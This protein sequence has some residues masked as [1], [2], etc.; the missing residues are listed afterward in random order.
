MGSFAGQVPTPLLATYSGTKS[1]LISFSQTLG[2]ELRRSKIDVQ[3]LNTYFVVSNMSKIRRSSSMI[4][5]PRQYVQQ[6]LSKI[7]RNG[8]AIGRA[9]TMTIWP[10]HALVDWAIQTF[11]FNQALF[12]RYNYSECADLY[13]I[14]RIFSFEYYSSRSNNGYKKESN[15]EGRTSKQ[16]P[17]DRHSNES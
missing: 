8:G 13:I 14:S 17:I 12:L 4:P 9:Y 10:M 15:K 16:K 2:E 11:V 3:C 7:G 5:T 6:V 1:F